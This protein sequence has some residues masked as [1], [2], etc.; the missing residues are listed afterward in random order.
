MMDYD[1]TV[2]GNRPLGLAQEE[3]WIQE[4][5]FPI[6]QLCRELSLYKGWYGVKYFAFA[7]GEIGLY[8]PYNEPMYGSIEKVFGFLWSELSNLYVN[9]VKNE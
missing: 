2:I 5:A 9:G 8:K 3:L 1:P 6:F 7:S 4:R